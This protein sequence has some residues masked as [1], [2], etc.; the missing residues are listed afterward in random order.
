M[1]NPIFNLTYYFKEAFTVAGKDRSSHIMSILSLAMIF[2]ILS[3]TMGVS[4]TLNY[5]SKTMEQEAEISVYYADDSALDSLID[6]LYSIEG[7]KEINKVSDTEAK[8]KMTELL[9]DDSRVLALFDYNPFSPYLEVKVDIAET[10]H[11]VNEANSIDDIEFIRD[12]KEVLSK[13][14]DLSAWF[15][16]A[17]AFIMLAVGIATVVL[18]SHIIRQGIYINR[19]EIGTL[20]LLGAPD[21][22]IY[23]PFIVNGILVSVIAGL[24]SLLL[25]FGAV[26]NLYS[27]VSGTVPFLTLPIKKSLLTNLAIFTVAT[28]FFLGLTGALTGIASTKPK[29]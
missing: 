18:T 19:N 5:L 24:L 8:D 14:K 16:L 7:V 13:I 3:M 26:S 29:N 9:G 11:I 4:V 6:K 23:F 21:M 2:F 27:S 15:S 28:S 17:G 1:K 12:N 22:F 10:E 20:K 25:T